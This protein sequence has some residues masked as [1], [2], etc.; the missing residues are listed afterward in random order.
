[1]KEP[2]SPHDFVQYK[3]YTFTQLQYEL[4]K[5][6]GNVDEGEVNYFDPHEAIE[7]A[8]KIINDKTRNDVELNDLLKRLFAFEDKVIDYYRL[9]YLK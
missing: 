5:K 8:R 1:M 4:Y 3:G 9:M 2:K 6:A 7:K